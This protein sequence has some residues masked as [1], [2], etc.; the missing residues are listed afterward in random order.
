MTTSSMVDS[1]HIFSIDGMTNFLDNQIGIDGQIIMTSDKHKGFYG[2]I[3]LYPP[4]YLSA[5][6]DY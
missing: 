2:S 4:G 6:V 5:W 1:A 3:G